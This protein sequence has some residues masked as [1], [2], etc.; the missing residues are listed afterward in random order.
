MWYTML[1]TLSAGNLASLVPD[2][3][4]ISS[5]EAINQEDL[6]AIDS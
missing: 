6:N 4:A 3:D 5:G 2:I 1:T